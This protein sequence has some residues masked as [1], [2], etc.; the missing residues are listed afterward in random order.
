MS[1]QLLQ[2][3]RFQPL[4]YQRVWGGRA[5]NS[6]YAKELPQD[7]QPY[8]ESWEIVDRSDAQSVVSEGSF[9]GKTLNQL[10]NEHY[11]QVFGLQEKPA[12]TRF[13]V[14]C[15]IL[16]AQDDLSLQVHPPADIAASLGGEPKNEMWYVTAAAEGAK[17][18]AGMQRDLD[19]AGIADALNNGSILEEVKCFPVAKHD[20]IYIPSGC[21]HAIGAGLVIFEIQQNSDTTYRVFDWN[22]LGLDGQPRELH[23]EESLASIDYRY[24]QVQLNPAEAE[25]IADNADF[26][27]KRLQLAAGTQLFSTPQQGFSLLAV[28]EG[29]LQCTDG[30]LIKPGDFVLLPH[31]C[32]TLQARQAVVALQVFC[33]VQA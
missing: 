33:H 9:A 22:R 14:L 26:S 10:W 16:D 15:K 24:N 1:T 17:L 6:I 12:A 2:P 3:I 11:A 20:S 31:N 18:Y 29:E 27:I 30:S 8:G 25:V 32:S 5:I 28:V 7:D 23:I 21:L 19:C 4:F 13:P